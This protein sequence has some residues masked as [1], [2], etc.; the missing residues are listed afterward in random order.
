MPTPFALTVPPETVA[1]LALE[2]VQV[3]L[4]S[5]AFEGLTVAVR[6]S[7]SPFE[8]ERV[9]LFKTILVIA[10]GLLCGFSLLPPLSFSE[11]SSVSDSSPIPLPHSLSGSVSLSEG[12][13]PVLLSGVS[14]DPARE[15]RSRANHHQIRTT[16]ARM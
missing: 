2:V 10:T 6:V 13:V 12:V 15:A 1:T 14:V 7:L 4:L 16:R 8:S 9:V 3:T 11:S 5:V